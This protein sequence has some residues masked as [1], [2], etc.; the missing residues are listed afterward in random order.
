MFSTVKTVVLNIP[1]FIL[2]THFPPQLDHLSLRAGND[3]VDYPP[4]DQIDLLFQ[5][6]VDQLDRLRSLTVML[7]GES[8]KEEHVKK[9][10]ASCQQLRDLRLW[11]SVY[12]SNIPATR[13]IPY[14]HPKLHR[15]PELSIT[16]LAL[17]PHW[18][19]NLTH[20]SL[21]EADA[22]IKTLVAP[23]LKFVIMRY[24][25]ECASLLDSAPHLAE[26]HLEDLQI[27]DSIALVPKVS[28][29]KGISSLSCHAG[30]G[31]AISA[32]S[33]STLLLGLPFLRGVTAH[34]LL[35]ANAPEGWLKHA[36]LAHLILS[37]RETQE[38]R[39]GNFQRLVLSP[40]TFP[41]LHTARID[42]CCGIE[43]LIVKDLPLLYSL[44]IHANVE[45]TTPAVITI[46]RCAELKRVELLHFHLGNFYFGQLPSL[47]YLAVSL[48]FVS[49]E[50]TRVEVADLPL[51][52]TLVAS[53]SKG[54]QKL[55]EDALLSKLQCDD[56]GPPPTIVF[57][58]S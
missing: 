44:K 46:K 7:S 11:N 5:V 8:I 50:S 24:S 36:G 18:L 40:E 38:D 28:K 30:S 43:Q 22:A 48:V 41:A 31:A 56:K 20:L 37:F 15:L 55:W 9:V 14:S 32:T 16:G 3:S 1:E 23:S 17:V 49:K 54:T 33:L 26:L 13:F 47:E 19:P 2:I 35:D 10:L 21:H 25:M 34:V 45:F 53:L 58:A 52:R 57:T 42:G 4:A 39:C 27:P 29:M 12:D 51:I 6:L